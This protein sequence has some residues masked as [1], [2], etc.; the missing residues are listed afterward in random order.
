[1]FGPLLHLIAAGHGLLPR[2]DRGG[3]EVWLGAFAGG[4]IAVR[5]RY[6][7]AAIGA[8]TPGI[9]SGVKKLLVGRKNRIV[10]KIFSFSNL[11]NS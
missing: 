6:I 9:S 11:K 8:I 7:A 1:L 10:R 3:A 5:A 4:A 2:A